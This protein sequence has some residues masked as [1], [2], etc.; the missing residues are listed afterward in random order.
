LIAEYIITFQV[1]QT[2]SFPTPIYKL[3]SDKLARR[4]AS[5]DLYHEREKKLIEERTQLQHSLIKKGEHS[6]WAVDGEARR[7]LEQWKQEEKNWAEGEVFKTLDGLEDERSE[8]MSK[9]RSCKSGKTGGGSSS[10]RPPMDKHYPIEPGIKGMSTDS[11][12]NPKS[13]VDIVGS[14]SNCIKKEEEKSSSKHGSDSDSD[15]ESEGSSDSESDDDGKKKKSKE[16]LLCSSSESE[17]SELDETLGDLKQKDDKKRKEKMTPEEEDARRQELIEQKKNEALENEYEKAQRKKALKDQGIDSDEDFV[18]ILPPDKELPEVRFGKGKTEKLVLPM[19]TQARPGVPAR[20]RPGRAPPHPKELQDRANAAAAAKQRKLVGEL[21]PEEDDPVWLKDKGDS[22]MQ[23]GD[24]QSAHEMYTT[25][26]RDYSNAACFANRALAAL[27]LGNLQQCVEDCA[28]SLRVLDMKLQVP[29]GHCPPPRDPQDERIRARALCRRGVAFLWLGEYAKAEESFLDSLGEFEGYDADTKLK[30]SYLTKGGG[31]TEEEQQEIRR[32]LKRLGELR[33]MMGKKEEIEDEIKRNGVDLGKK[34]EIEKYKIKEKYEECQSVL[35]SDGNSNAMITGSL[36]FLKLQLGD[37][38]GSLKEAKSLASQVSRWNHV[39][40]GPPKLCEK[41]QRLDPP[42]LED[43]TFA[44]PVT[45]KQDDTSWLMKHCSD[46]KSTLPPIPEDYEWV[47]DATEK[48][49]ENAW[50]AIRKRM[51]AA[52]IKSIRE[53]IHA[54]QE[55]LYTRKLET[56]DPAIELAK[57]QNEAREGPCNAAIQQAMDFRQKLSEYYK[58]EEDK[59]EEREKEREREEKESESWFLRSFIAGGSGGSGGG[60][61][62]CFKRS[63]PVEKTRRKIFM[64]SKLREVKALQL[65]AEKQQKL[66]GQNKMS[67]SNCQDLELLDINESDLPKL[68]DKALSIVNDLILK[69]EPQNE[70]ALNL[71][72][73]LIKAIRVRDNLDEVEKQREV[74]RL[75]KLGKFVPKKLKSEEQESSDKPSLDLAEKILEQNKAIGNKKFVEQPLESLIASSSGSTTTGESS[76]SST[77]SGPSSNSSAKDD[78]KKSIKKKSN[79]DDIDLSSD[80]EDEED[81][82]LKSVEATKTLI[83]SATKYL[84]QQ[85][86][87]SALQIYSYALRMGNFGGP[88]NKIEKF[89]VHLNL[90]LCLQKARRVKDLVEAVKQIVEEIGEEK[91][92]VSEEDSNLKGHSSDNN[93]SDGETKV[94]LAQLTRLEAAC[95]TRRAW[96]FNQLGKEKEAKDDARKAKSL[97]GSLG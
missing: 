75:K 17:D 55:A 80:D 44:N 79:D 37:Y 95:Y 47:K 74:E 62:G 35:E 70:D 25:A 86:F 1:P 38:V 48:K 54:L 20:D 88:E 93:S 76:K 65:M 19:T 33:E 3:Q 51:T 9:A 13:R 18:E 12:F 46:D 34:H 73:Q 77:T 40:R 58:E 41:P 81:G 71:K 90:C 78:S 49:E 10:Y 69:A 24:Y 56:V 15:N 36:Q 85:Q 22:H 64:K 16:R 72:E 92:R 68:E 32:D 84:E 30:N 53:K 63:H 21:D 14:D 83:A 60:L 57:I 96:A 5:L 42:L 82:A 89:R 50:I 6:Q 67:S 97:L 91:E 87:E 52:Q 4:R 43:H 61:T 31:L 28:H 26:L 39:P 11:I 2:N 8:I 45:H 29:A 7:K 94:K 59:R 66:Q 23:A 27:Y